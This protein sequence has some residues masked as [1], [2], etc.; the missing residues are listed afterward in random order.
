VG[1]FHLGEVGGCTRDMADGLSGVGV[2]AVA[3]WASAG[4]T[5]GFEEVLRGDEGGGFEGHFGI[6]GGLGKEIKRGED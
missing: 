4:G 3:G 2:Y 5:E 6:G 1:Y